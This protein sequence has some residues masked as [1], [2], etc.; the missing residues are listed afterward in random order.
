MCSQDWRRESDETMAYKSRVKLLLHDE[1]EDLLPVEVDRSLP[2]SDQ[3]PST[4]H[5]CSHGEPVAKASVGR[6][7]ADTPA[8]A[9]PENRAGE[10]FKM[11]REKADAR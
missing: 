11:E 5:E 9:Y 8:L 7:K 10:P 2:V 1:L 4:L 6:R 3:T